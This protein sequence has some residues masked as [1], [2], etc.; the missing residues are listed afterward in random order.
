MDTR[1][2]SAGAGGDDAAALAA[3]DAIAAGAVCWSLRS[4]DPSRLQMGARGGQTHLMEHR[5]LGNLAT[6]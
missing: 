1:S 4:P 3:V 2:S 5:Q 6:R